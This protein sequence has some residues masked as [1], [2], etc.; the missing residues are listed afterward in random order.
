MRPGPDLSYC[1]WGSA[2]QGARCV[3]RLI[4]FRMCRYFTALRLLTLTLFPRCLCSTGRVEL[5]FHGPHGRFTLAS[6]FTAALR[7]VSR[8]MLCFSV[9]P[10][11]YGPFRFTAFFVLTPLS[12]FIPAYRAWFSSFYN[13]GDVRF[14]GA[15][16]V[17]YVMC[18]SDF[19]I[20][21]SRS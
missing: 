11:I 18:L 6:R 10:F 1:Y 15:H 8:Q 2:W 20:S 9:I 3:V 5:W 16:K 12:E 17:S 7:S 19:T 14:N 21:E 13:P 4:D